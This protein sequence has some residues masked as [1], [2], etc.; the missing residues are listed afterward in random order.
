MAMCE[1]GGY[2]CLGVR[3]CVHVHMGTA[4]VC[5]CINRYVWHGDSESPPGMRRFIHCILLGLSLPDGTQAI[6]PSAL[7]RPY[8]ALHWELWAGFGPGAGF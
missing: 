8:F 2:V 5:L 7:R 6:C 4:V 3:G 1:V